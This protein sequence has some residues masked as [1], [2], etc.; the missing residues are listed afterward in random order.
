M[1]IILGLLAAVAYGSSDFAAGVA[2]RRFAVGPVTLVVQVFCLLA[3]VIAVLFASGTGPAGHALLWG[4]ISGIGS[5]IGTLLLYRGLSVS[6]MSVVATA[7]AVLT[8]VIPAVVG[9]FLG[10]RPAPLTIVGIAAAV[11]AIALVSWQ[12]KTGNDSGRSARAGLGY[13]IAA[14][15]GFALLFIALH[16]AGTGSGAWPLVPGQAVSLLVIIPFVHLGRHLADLRQQPAEWWRPLIVQIVAA[17]VLSGMANL[18]YLAATGHGALSVVAVL[19][20]L[21]P[22][23]TVLLARAILHEHWTRLQVVGL[24]TAAVAIGLVTVS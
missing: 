19:T 16:R 2:S 4:A 14:G 21:Y 6:Q 23:A 11:P 18:L 5:G 10:E 7:S 1:G 12:P 3:A 13:G 8:A 9:F 24:L 17:G 22:A 20:A 15:A